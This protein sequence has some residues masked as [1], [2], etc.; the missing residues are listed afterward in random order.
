MAAELL[1]QMH[2]IAGLDPI[3]NWPLAIGWWLILLLTILTTGLGLF[4]YLQRK[5]YRNSWLYLVYLNL[6]NLEAALNTKSKKY[7]ITELSENLRQLAIK[8]YP[9]AD[10]A[11]IAGNNWLAWL[12]EHDKK[13]FSWSTHGNILVLGPY[14]PN[15]DNVSNAEIKL[16]IQAAKRWAK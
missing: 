2:D 10:C 1:Q 4:F 6:V 3:G 16:L 14:A 15:L 7:I 13:K 9:R 5:K 11:S 8:K 12:E